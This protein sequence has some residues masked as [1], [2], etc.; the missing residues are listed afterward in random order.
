MQTFHSIPID[1]YGQVCIAFKG[2]AQGVEI[3][4]SQGIEPHESS[5][6]AV[7]EVD[8]S[9]VLF[10][11][12]RNDID[13]SLAGAVVKKILTADSLA[14]SRFRFGRLVKVIVPVTPPRSIKGSLYTL[15]D[16]RQRTQPLGMIIRPCLLASLP[17]IENLHEYQQVG[18]E[19]LAG[20][21]AAVLADDMGLGKTAQAISALRR[22]FSRSPLNSALVVCPKQL[23]A[24]WEDELAKWAPELSWSRLT[25]PTRWREQAWESLF[26]RVHLIITNYEQISSIHTFASDFQFSTVI[27]DEAHRVRNANAR[28]TSDLRGIA[29]DRTWALTG[30]PFERAPSDVWTILSVVEPRRFNLTRMRRSEESIRARARPYV[31]RRMK[32]DLLPSLPPEIDEHETTE[33]LP[34]QR[35]AYNRALTGFRT[36]SDHDRLAKLNELRSLCDFDKESGQSA[37]LERIVDIL[38]AVVLSGEKAVVFSHLLYP[39]DM[40]GQ[41]LDLTSMGYIQ[42]RGD[43]SILEREQAVA[44]FNQNVATSF[45]LAS[46]RVGGEGLNLVEA[47]HVVFVNRWW[48]PSA[49]NQAKDRVSRMGQTRTVTVHSFTCR[50]T[51]EELLDEIIAEKGRLADIIIESLADPTSHPSVLNEVSVRLR[52][53]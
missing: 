49:N 4:A 10:P 36:A 27:L 29:R 23:M 38:H 31:L 41:L 18:V 48:N 11:I 30:T 47:N 2:I 32:R 45:L 5:D 24:N 46:T 9:E 35:D 39:L 37:K 1:D 21:S 25:A 6:C 50:D 51:V 33:L 17:G 44:Q 53:R 14:A 8:E 15:G 3:V 13:S 12:F 16:A 7:C 52:K 26:N 42:L 28:V 40:L 20:R 43:Q 34:K 19:W 22:L